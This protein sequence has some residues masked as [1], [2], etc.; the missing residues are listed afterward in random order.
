MEDPLDR[1]IDLGA[2]PGLQLDEP[3]RHVLQA[4]NDEDALN[5][6]WPIIAMVLLFGTVA[7]LSVGFVLRSP[8][9]AP[10]AEKE[11]GVKET[12]VDLPAPVASASAPNAPTASATEPA[13]LRRDR[14]VAPSAPNAPNGAVAPNLGRLLVRSSPADADVFVNGTP[15]G[16]T[17]L[18]LRDLALG[19][20]TIRVAR[21]G[22][23]T[24]ER[25]LRLTE[26]Q[27]STSTTVALVAE[28]TGPGKLNVQSRPAGAR[29]FVND[30]LAGT[31]PISISSLPAGSATVRIEMG[32]YRVWSTRVNVKAGE[33]TRV[34]AS[35]ERP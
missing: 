32:G 12:I 10:V 3:P 6:P 23:A 22:Y 31:T 15:R 18:V 4:S 11:T 2:P 33:S 24:E 27:P 35:L 19:S 13:E 1:E 5:R 30:R 28:K 21:A 26:Q 25:T 14:P 17:P 16:K 8:R 34:T 9:P 20:Y 7:A 29:V